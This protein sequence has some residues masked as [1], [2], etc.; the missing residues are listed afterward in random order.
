LEKNHPDI[1]FSG[2]FNSCMRGFLR[3]G[4]LELFKDMISVYSYAE[5]RPLL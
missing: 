4:V 5:D 2:A 3:V 1:V